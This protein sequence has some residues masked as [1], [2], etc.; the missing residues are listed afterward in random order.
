MFPAE[1]GRMGFGYKQ[2]FITFTNG[3]AL[4]CVDQEWVSRGRRLTEVFIVAGDEDVTDP[5]LEQ[6]VA[7]RDAGGDLQP[8]PLH[9]PIRYDAEEMANLIEQLSCHCGGIHKI[10]FDKAE[11]DR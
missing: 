11:V 7:A 5:L 9:D 2:V 10:S 8:L 4:S 6:W 1:Y 3:I